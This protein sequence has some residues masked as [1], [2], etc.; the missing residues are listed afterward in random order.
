MLEGM[1]GRFGRERLEVQQAHR[2]L[3]R[4]VWPPPLRGIEIGR[5][6]HQEEPRGHLGAGGPVGQQATQEVLGLDRLA[7][8]ALT[9]PLDA[10]LLRWKATFALPDGT[11]EPAVTQRV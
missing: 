11:V 5:E 6:V 7:P 9:V 3:A 10:L 1:V 4:G 8:R 2:V